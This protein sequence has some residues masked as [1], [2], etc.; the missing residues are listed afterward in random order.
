MKDGFVYPGGAR[1]AISFTIDDGNLPMDRKFIDIVKPAGIKGT[2]N[3]CSDHLNVMTPEEYREFYQGYEIANHSKA[4]PF[5]LTEEK[6]RPIKWEKFDASV[7]DEGFMYPLKEY[8]DVFYYRLPHGWRIGCY[9]S[10]FIR[11]VEECNREL[12]EIFGIGS[13]RSFVWPFGEQKSEKVKEYLKQYGFYGIRKTGRVDDTTGF[14]LPA[15][16]NAWSYNA[17]HT[18]LLSCAQKF[19]KIPD[20]GA[21]K[22]FSFGVHSV[23]FERAGNWCDLERFAKEYGNRPDAYYYA[24]IG[25]IFDYE[26]RTKLCNVENGELHNGSD[27][28]VYYLQ[29]DKLLTVGAGQSKKLV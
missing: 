9:E 13:V 23:D 28:E 21:L 18:T 26:D 12:E 19:E 22:F 5:P 8:K 15:D 7:A 16:R 10:A 20:D 2:F 24:T 25:E 3:L 1:K 14:A 17:D 11:L 27:D 29:G 6:Y 4:H